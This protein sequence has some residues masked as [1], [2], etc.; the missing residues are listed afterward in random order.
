MLE[1]VK[2][3]VYSRVLKELILFKFKLNLTLRV[4]IFLGFKVNTV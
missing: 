2:K 4:I 1:Y 3:T